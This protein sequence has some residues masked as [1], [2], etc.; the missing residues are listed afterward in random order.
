MDD[1]QL[2]EE[3][4]NDKSLKQETK[5]EVL[6]EKEG[7]KESEKENK[8]ERLEKRIA[9]LEDQLKRAVAD[10]RN[11]ERRSL[12]ER[13]EAIKF[14][15]KKFIEALLPAFDTLFL[16]EKYTTDESVKLTISRIIEVLKEN[17]IEKIGTH[18]AKYNAEL[19]EVVEVVEGEKDKVIEEI[20]PG[21]TV[22]GKLIRPAQVKVG[23]GN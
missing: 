11:L 18:D 20:R 21:F 8:Y 10:Y 4:T 3:K 7:V 19:M 14:A 6:D 16:A 9:E 13:G 17:G 5:E 2:K 15:N 22:Y 12:E 23:K 1:K